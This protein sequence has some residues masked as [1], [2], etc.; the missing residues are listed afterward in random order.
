M[1]DLGELFIQAELSSKYSAVFGVYDERTSDPLIASNNGI[2]FV[3][4]ILHSIALPSLI[5]FLSVITKKNRLFF[6]SLSIGIFS[7]IIL[8]SFTHG[9]IWALKLFYPFDNTR[10][11]IFAD[12]VGNW[13]D[14]HPKFSVLFFK[15]P[16]YCLIIWGVLISVNLL[17]NRY[18]NPLK[19]FLRKKSKGLI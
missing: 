7:H 14:W 17:M 13:W 16:F 12:S 6:R 5:F 10:Y 18:N 4:D 3:Y 11:K 1:P 2:T 9:K 15:L 19:R 8:D